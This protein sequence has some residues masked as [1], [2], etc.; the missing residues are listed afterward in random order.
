MN[1]DIELG[2]KIRKDKAAIFDL[3]VLFL[4]MDA[5]M[6]QRAGYKN[7]REAIFQT[8]KNANVR[9]KKQIA[10]HEKAFPQ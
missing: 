8:I 7:G 9:F 10:E 6:L 4:N 5:D 2:E 1:K 3:C